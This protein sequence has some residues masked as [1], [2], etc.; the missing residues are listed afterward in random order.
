MVDVPR[1]LWSSPEWLLFEQIVNITLYSAKATQS[2]PGN[3]G[4]TKKAY[5]MFTDSN[6][7]QYK[8]KCDVL[9]ALGVLLALRRI[10]LQVRSDR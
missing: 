5:H 1:L 8:D 6:K 2:C 4:K 3:I 9:S 10:H 7:T